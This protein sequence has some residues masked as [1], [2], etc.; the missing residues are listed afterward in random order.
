MAAPPRGSRQPTR[1]SSRTSEEVVRRVRGRRPQTR[2]RGRGAPLVLP[3]GRGRR[4]PTAAGGQR[5]KSILV[6]PLAVRRLGRRLRRARG[7]RVSIPHSGAV[8]SR[9]HSRAAAARRGIMGGACRNRSNPHMDESP[10]RQL[11]VGQLAQIPPACS[12]QSHRNNRQNRPCAGP[13]HPPS[14]VCCHWAV[15][16]THCGLVS[17][18]RIPHAEGTAEA[19]RS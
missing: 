8:T 1:G 6:P 15:S 14:S 18:R 13:I 7:G 12:H 16:G 3:V 10:S 19:R 9:T 11:A 2:W 4:A 5:M 17:L